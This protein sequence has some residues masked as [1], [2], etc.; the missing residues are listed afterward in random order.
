[1]RTFTRTIVITCAVVAEVGVGRTASAQLNEA[2]KFTTTFPFTAGGTTLPAGAYTVRPLENDHGVMLISNGRDTKI[3]DVVPT[4]A[5]S[6]QPVKDEV[7]FRK[8]PVGYVLS[9]IWDA[10]ERSGVQTLPSKA[11]GHIHHHHHHTA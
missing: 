1:M 7:V 5:A 3:L 2:I 4:G 11:E 10:A 8:E 9:Q 6:T